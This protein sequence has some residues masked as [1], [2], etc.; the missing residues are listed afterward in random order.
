[1]PGKKYKNVLSLVDSKKVYT[2]EEAVA[3]AKKTAI[4]KFDSSID[5]AIKLNLDT[6]KAE[7]Q[8]RGTIALPHYFGKSKRVLLISSDVTDAQAKEAGADYFGG[9]DKIADIKNG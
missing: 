5:I 3:L 4:T 6:T 8:L 7:Q 9:S 2:V 1:M